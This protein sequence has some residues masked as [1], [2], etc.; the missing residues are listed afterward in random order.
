ML[1]V[2]I[3]PI[4]HITIA[5]ND[6]SEMM[7]KNLGI[8]DATSSVEKIENMVTG[9]AQSTAEEAAQKI[10]NMVT[11]GAEKAGEVVTGGANKQVK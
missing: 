6:T 8:D 3:A 5:Q 9:G 1:A 10:E 4:S 7:K 11:G 2:L